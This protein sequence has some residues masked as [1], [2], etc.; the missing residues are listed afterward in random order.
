MPMISHRLWW[1]SLIYALLQSSIAFLVHSAAEWLFWNADC[2]FYLFLLTVKQSHLVNSFEK[3]EII[4][5]LRLLAVT[6]VVCMFTFA[7]LTNIW[8][9][10]INKSWLSLVFFIYLGRPIMAVAWWKCIVRVFII[11]LTISTIAIWSDVHCVEHFWMFIKES[12][13][14]RSRSKGITRIFF[15]FNFIFLI[16]K[17][18]FEFF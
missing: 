1:P 6:K 12:C 5:A 8:T 3:R 13:W 4:L 2:D 9:R 16:R 11:I 14:R 18:C 17:Y 10:R 7:L 15:N